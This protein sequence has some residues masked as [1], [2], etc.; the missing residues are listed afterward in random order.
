[1]SDCFHLAHS[2]LSLPRNSEISGSDVNT[3][4]PP[5]GPLVPWSPG[6]M[7]K[8]CDGLDNEES[9]EVE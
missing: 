8:H 7:D 5:V 9:H 1:M 6:H 3:A 4:T 2:S